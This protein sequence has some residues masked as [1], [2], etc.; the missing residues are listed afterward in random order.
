MRSSA[1]ISIS[2]GPRTLTG[3]P[4]RSRTSSPNRAHRH[5]V[6]D[7]NDLEGRADVV[8][9]VKE[10]YFALRSSNP[11]P[12]LDQIRDDL[13]RADAA[14]GPIIEEA[15]LAARRSDEKLLEATAA[16]ETLAAESDARGVALEAR[17][18]EVQQLQEEA[19][20]LTNAAAASR[21]ARCRAL[22]RARQGAEG[23]RRLRGSEVE[24]PG[25]RGGTPRWGGPR[26]AQ[27]RAEAAEP[28]IAIARENLQDALIEVERLTAQ[29]NQ[30]ALGASQRSRQRPLPSAPLC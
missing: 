10:T 21:P 2:S 9:W 19:A 13:A 12:I 25:L 7:W 27:S 5:H 11:V 22:G 15:R 6:F 14:F 23:T 26:A 24:V 1:P 18:A 28:E 30:S 20:G 17:A 29:A 4:S 16:R 3:P 8:S